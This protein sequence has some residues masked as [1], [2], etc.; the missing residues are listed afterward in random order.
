MPR[1]DVLVYLEGGMQ[2][3]PSPGLEIVSTMLIGTATKSAAPMTKK[4]QL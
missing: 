4:F 1:S 2:Q 3:I